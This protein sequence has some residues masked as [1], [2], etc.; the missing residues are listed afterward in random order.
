MLKENFQKNIIGRYINIS[1]LD[2]PLRDL[3][4]VF[5]KNDLKFIFGEKVS[6]ISFLDEVEH[7]TW[8]THLIFKL[9]HSRRIVGYLRV[10]SVQDIVEIHGGG[11]NKTIIEK[12]ALTEAWQLIINKCF[13]IF[14]VNCIYT[15][16]MI[17]NRKAYNFISGTGF[18]EISCNETENRISFKLD[19]TDYK[20]ENNKAQLVTT[21]HT[22]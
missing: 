6:D 4:N 2:F 16:C 21:A 5:S 13:Q 14:R 10:I 18:K 22:Q 1:N 15:S 7:D 17:N 3:S 8:S 20:I 11:L 19:Y 9:N 12:M